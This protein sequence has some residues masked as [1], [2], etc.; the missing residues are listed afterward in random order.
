MDPIGSSRTSLLL[1]ISSL[2]VER[3]YFCC[4]KYMKLVMKYYVPLYGVTSL[5][6]PG[7]GGGAG[8]GWFSSKLNKTYCSLANFYCKW[9]ENGSVFVY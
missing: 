2:V 6:L 4:V 5:M 7:G 8:N 1:V 9:S 3:Q